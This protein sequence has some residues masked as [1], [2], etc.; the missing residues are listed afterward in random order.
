MADTALTIITD[1]L[2]DIG[3][4][5]DEEVPTASQASS[6]LRK[7]NNMIDSWNIENLAI[8]GATEYVLP[9][10]AGQG[11]YTIG[12]GGDLNVPR[13]NNITSAAARDLTLPPESQVDYPLYIMSDLEYQSIVLKGLQS[14]WP[15][16]AIWFNKTYPLIEAYV[17][18]V[19]T[20]SNFGVS[21]WDSGILNNFTL[22]QVVNLAPGYK[23]SIT[24]NLCLELAGGYGVSV[25]D[26]VQTIAVQSKADIK[27]KNLQVNELSPT[28]RGNGRYNIFTDGANP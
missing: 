12:E 8:Y 14:P 17:Y 6:A 11:K 5:A 27:T 9:M 7:L 20:G 18:P 4:L 3:V 22:H 23:R 24:A 25:P 2:M 28:G 1:A 26:T 19:P 15:N 10:V 21:M 13:P 16:M